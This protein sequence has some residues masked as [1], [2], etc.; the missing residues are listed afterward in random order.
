MAVGERG[1]QCSTSKRCPAVV[2]TRA[3]APCV[4]MIESIGK[5]S[6]SKDTTEYISD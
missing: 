4:N 1:S 6:Q 3:R 2:G 5:F